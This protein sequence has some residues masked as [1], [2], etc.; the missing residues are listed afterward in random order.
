MEGV[1]NTN[2]R[3]RSKAGFPYYPFHFCFDNDAHSQATNYRAFCQSVDYGLPASSFGIL[4]RLSLPIQDCP[5]LWHTLSSLSALSP[6]HI[7]ARAFSDRTVH[8]GLKA[9]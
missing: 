7:R 6:C 4:N 3:A 8:L 5:S 9:E 1:T 2:A